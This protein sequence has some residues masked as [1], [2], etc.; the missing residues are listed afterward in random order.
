MHVSR[1]VGVRICVYMCMVLLM[2]M[3]ILV[4]FFFLL[5]SGRVSVS[6]APSG[7]RPKFGFA[8]LGLLLSTQILFPDEVVGENTIRE[9]LF[10]MKTTSPSRQH[11]LSVGAPKARGLRHP[12]TD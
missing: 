2:F 12:S 4:I 8:G 11:Q 7:R 10:L 6:P 3:V 5:I 1:Y 9:V